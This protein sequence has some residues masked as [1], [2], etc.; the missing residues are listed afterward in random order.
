MTAVDDPGTAGTVGRAGT[1]ELPGESLHVVVNGDGPTVVFA[2]GLGESW[3][4]WDAVV[5]LL[6]GH[7]LVRFDRPGLGGT[8]LPARK[9]DLAAELA[10]IGAV[11]DAYSPDAPVVLV[12]H[13]AAA[14]HAEA[15]T[16]LHPARVAALL[17]VDPSSEPDAA[18]PVTPARRLTDLLLTGL[19]RATSALAAT[20]ITP[21]LGPRLFRL[22][23]RGQNRRRL[24]GPD[25]PGWPP[26]TD[27]MPHPVDTVYGSP[28]AT[29]TILA[30]LAAYRSQAADLN[31]LRRTTPYPGVPTTV[32][33][34]LDGLTPTATTDHLAG[35]THLAHLLSATHT[36]LP[37]ARHLAM[38]D[39]PAAVADAITALHT[40]SGN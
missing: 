39:E 26:R 7:R 1:V 29:V 11:A 3:F 40:A 21:L 18:P 20:R 37:D 19:P 32:L 23:Y 2:N 27:P 22:A 12:A 8:P 4:D 14:L 6:P 10:R 13:S 28:A 38:L 34:A 15:Y 35:T 36:P 31:A 9:P 24:R 5:P 25:A 16:R 33:A 17:L 30:E